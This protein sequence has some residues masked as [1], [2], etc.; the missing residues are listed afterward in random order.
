MLARIS[1]PQAQ[2]G[3]LK[4]CAPG[5]GGPDGVGPLPG[6]GLCRH[7]RWRSR[8]H[9]QRASRPACSR[10]LPPATAGGPLHLRRRVSAVKALTRAASVARG[11]H[12]RC[13][14]QPNN[15]RCLSAQLSEL[16]QAMVP[17]AAGKS[18]DALLQSFA[19]PGRGWEAHALRSRRYRPLPGSSAQLTRPPGRDSLLRIWMVN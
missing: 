13:R 18:S 1:R 14:A 17:T 6:A 10:I 3:N 9:W 4:T 16:S 8:P 11:C 19:Y 7:Q 12:R 15:W 5:A 2:T